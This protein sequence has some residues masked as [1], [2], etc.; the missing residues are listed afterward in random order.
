ME[1]CLRQA[2]HRQNKNEMSPQDKKLEIQQSWKF[3]NPP[4]QKVQVCF[5]SWKYST[6]EF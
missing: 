4:T 3:C 6:T 1:N 2:M 5:Y